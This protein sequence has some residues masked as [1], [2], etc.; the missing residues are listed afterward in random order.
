LS[1]F[2]DALS[3]R[4]EDLHILD[5][6]ILPHLP[7]QDIL[8]TLRI[9]HEPELHYVR[10]LE[11]AFP[12]GNSAFLTLREDIDSL[13][14]F[15]G[16]LQKEFLRR[17][18][19]SVSEFFEGNRIRGQLLPVLRPDIA[20]LIQPDLFNTN[21]D[22]VLS[23]IG[24]KVDESWSQPVQQLLELPLVVRQQRK[25]IWDLISLPIRQQVKSFVELALAIDKLS[26]GKRRKESL[27]VGERA[28]IERLGVRIADL[29]RGAVDDPM[30]QFLT[31]A[32]Q[33]LV[34]VPQQMDQVPIEV[35]RAL[36]DVE[37]IMRL[38]KQALGQR[39]Q[40]LL[41]FH[42]L[43]MARLCGENG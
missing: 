31:S 17:Q 37:Q 22:D 15:I 25:D 5:D 3:S 20:V 9:Y 4:G 29:L 8:H 12:A 35:L 2:A 14:H 30:R 42:I 39:E 43:Q 1:E 18:G 27:L 16:L 10:K 6:R 23:Y 28:E 32:V 24:S 33:Y 26:T 11:T 21:I 40:D 41:R 19:L 13:F 7:V 34:Q 36:R 38:E